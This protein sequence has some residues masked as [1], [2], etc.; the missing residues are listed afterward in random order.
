MLLS[1]ESSITT[2]RYSFSPCFQSAI[3]VRSLFRKSLTSSLLTI[4]ALVSF[5]PT[6]V[7]VRFTVPGPAARTVVAA[8]PNAKPNDP[9]IKARRPRFVF[10]MIAMTPFSCLHVVRCNAGWKEYQTDEFGRMNEWGASV[11]P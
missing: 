1:R 5:F 9:T 3:W 8:D 6:A 11:Q 2:A 4:G 10:F 7:T